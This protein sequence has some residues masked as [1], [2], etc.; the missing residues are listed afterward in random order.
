[1]RLAH[2]TAANQA[3]AYLTG[4]HRT[5][6]KRGKA[7][8]AFHGG[9]FIPVLLL[10]VKTQRRVKQPMAEADEKAPK[11]FPALRALI[12]QRAGTLPKRLTQVATYALDNP[13]EIAF[14]TVASVAAQADV[15]PSALVRFAHALGYGGFSDLQDVF[16]SRLRERVLNYDERLARMQE[17]GIATSQAGLLLEGFLEAAERSIGE[18][19]ERTDATLLDRAVEVL[20]AAETIYLIGLRRSFPITS[21]MSY[22]LAK[23][24][25][26]NILV[27]GVAGLGAEQANFIGQRDAVLAVSFTPYANETVVLT[28]AADTR[29]A[30][31]V[32]ITDSVLSPI[33][34]PADVMLELVEANFEGFRSMAATMALAMCLTVS[35]AARRAEPGQHASRPSL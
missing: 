18:L 25:I 24:G 2:K 28:N 17:H 10:C 16:R 7:Q 15:Q 20:A 19:R 32:A 33:A 35:I 27:D 30:K 8:L 6:L 5:L 1:V 31:I 12:V 11:D 3:D 26:R 21:Y 23:S 34:P 4:S 29:G 13:D 22:A 14:G 9:I